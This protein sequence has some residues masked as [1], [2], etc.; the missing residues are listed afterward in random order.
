[1]ADQKR[2]H[3]LVEGQTEET[4]VREMIAP[5]FDAAGWLSTLSIVKTKR[6]AGGPSFRGGLTTWSQ[7]EREIRLLLRDTSIDVLTTV[8]DYY[9]FPADC[10]GM[11]ERLRLNSAEERVECVESALAKAIGDVRFR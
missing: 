8:V 3:F 5:Y 7:L 10:P 1:M 9:G 4:A 6:P 11:A 2:V